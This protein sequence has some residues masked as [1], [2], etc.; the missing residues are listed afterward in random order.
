[1]SYI[2]GGIRSFTSGLSKTVKPSRT[3]TT[4]NNAVK[5]N[6]LFHTASRSKQHATTTT[7][8]SNE[9]VSEQRQHLVEMGYSPKRLINDKNAN[10]VILDEEG[11][12]LDA[13]RKALKSSEKTA[14][15]NRN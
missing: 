9:N 4:L 3:I 6:D 11:I 10:A 2:I 8:K 13:F 14:D 1:M 5:N 12:Q 15:K 7:T